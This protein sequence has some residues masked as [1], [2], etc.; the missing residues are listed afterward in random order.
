MWSFS[1]KNFH[2]LKECSL[3]LELGEVYALVGRNGGGKTSIL[4][5][6]RKMQEASWGDGFSKYLFG[7]LKLSVG[8]WSWEIN[9]VGAFTQD[10]CLVGP[11]AKE[12]LCG[13]DMSQLTRPELQPLKDLLKM[14]VHTK[15]V[16]ENCELRLDYNDLPTTQKN[17]VEDQTRLAFP[18]VGI[19]S[20]HA[21]GLQAFF[22]H[23][24][25][26]VLAPPRSLLTFEAPEFQLHPRVIRQMLDV[27]RFKAREKELT[28]LLATHSPV[29]L[30]GF[31]PQELMENILVVSPEKTAPITELFDRNWLSHFAMGDLYAREEFDL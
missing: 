20:N 15:H 1:V 24:V 31:Q 30:N 21:G 22:L 19:E 6:L 11:L 2:A 12:E 4:Q 16:S 28:I 17:W 9:Q 23:M 26:L 13:R 14:K 3:Q 7:P 27:F 18:G 10:Q 29:L 8:E 25:A 5:A